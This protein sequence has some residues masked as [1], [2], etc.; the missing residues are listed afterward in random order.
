MTFTGKV[1]QI[2]AKE[3]KGMSTTRV[4]LMLVVTSFVVLAVG[5]GSRIADSAQ[6]RPYAREASNPGITVPYPG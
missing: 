6:A 3:G 2:L 4:W 5:F 1:A